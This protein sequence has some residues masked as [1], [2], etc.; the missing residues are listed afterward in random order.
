MSSHMLFTNPAN[1]ADLRY[2]ES[3]NCTKYQ[4]CSIIF[5]VA[6]ACDSNLTL[7]YGPA[8]VVKTGQAI[9]QAKMTGVD[10][11]PGH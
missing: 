9:I 7:A 4:V 6:I 2:S 10:D 1:V 5:H 3:S 8:T 11:E